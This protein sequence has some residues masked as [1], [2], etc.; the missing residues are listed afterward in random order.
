MDPRL[1]AYHAAVTAVPAPQ[2]DWAHLRLAGGSEAG[3]L[4][5]EE[6]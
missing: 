6:G 2:P 1:G 4:R 5:P 3:E